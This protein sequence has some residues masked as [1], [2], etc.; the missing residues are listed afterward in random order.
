VQVDIRRRLVEHQD[1]RVGDQGARERDQLTL[2]G[3]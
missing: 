1:P 2:A 3:R